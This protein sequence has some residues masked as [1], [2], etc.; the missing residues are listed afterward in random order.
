MHRAEFRIILNTFSNLLEYFKE[1][2]LEFIQHL[3]NLLIFF[4]RL[5]NHCKGFSN[6]A[7]F[8]II[9]RGSHNH[10]LLFHFLLKNRGDKLKYI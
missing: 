4:D 8:E 10:Q 7:S 2:L 6:F 1:V 5:H 3:H 9:I